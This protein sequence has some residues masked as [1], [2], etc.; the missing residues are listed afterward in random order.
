M[1]T[2]SVVEIPLDKLRCKP[3]IRTEFAEASL[4]GLAGTMKEL[5]QLVPII[6]YPE[7]EWFV[8]EE[9]ER[10]FRAAKLIGWPSLKALIKKPEQNEADLLMRQLVVNAQREENT[11]IERARA[12]QRL[13]ALNG[14]SATKVA[15]LS[16]TS[17]GTI[18]QLV[19]LLT[20]DAAI[21]AK[22]ASGEISR[23]AAYELAG[24][25]NSAEQADMASR[26]ASKEMTREQVKSQTNAAKNASP[27]LARITLTL[28][29]EM[30]VTIC[31]VDISAANVLKT[32]E[33]LVTKA[34][35]AIKEGLEIDTVARMLRDQNKLNGKEGNANA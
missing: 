31:G 35:K 11:P 9:G 3:Q 26:I 16:G 19:K 20:L 34:R 24:V 8:I 1:S 29:P 2:E 4:E 33:T 15:Q 6:V 21:Q 32:L 14:G 23:S 27:P 25:K 17:K 18:S 12:F 28:S 5:G 22:V 7:N 13:I 10:R 30:Q